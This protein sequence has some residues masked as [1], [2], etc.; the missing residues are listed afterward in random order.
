MSTFS[1]ISY[2]AFDPKNLIMTSFSPK[3]IEQK[4]NAPITYQESNFKYNYG[5][6][7]D[8]FYEE[9]P[10]LLNS[11]GIQEQTNTPQAGQN[12]Q[13]ANSG[14][15]RKTYQ[16]MSKLRPNVPDEA[17]LKTHL[18]LLRMAAAGLCIPYKVKIG[19]AEFAD[20]DIVK[21]LKPIYFLSKDKVT[22]AVLE[23]SSP[24]IYWPLFK[25]GYGVMEEKTTFV[26]LDGKVIPWEMLKGVEFEYKPLWKTSGVYVG[27]TRKIKTEL[28]SAVVRNIKMRQYV[29]AQKD[30]IASM[31][32][33]NPEMLKVFEDQ[34][35]KLKAE[36]EEIKATTANNPN[37]PAIAD[38]LGLTPNT[39]AVAGAKVP[40][41][42]PGATATTSVPQQNFQQQFQPPAQQ[43]SFQ[44]PPAQQQSFQQPPAQQQSFQQPPVQQQSPQQQF[45]LPQMPQMGNDMQLQLQQMMQQQ[46][47]QQQAQQQPPGMPNLA[48]FMKSGLP[49]IG[50]IQGLTP[51]VPQ[52]QTMPNVGGMKIN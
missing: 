25:R 35:R 51:G 19:L 29:D 21:C 16:I 1:K 28:Y 36:Q 49:Q 14:F 11:G 31:V 40:V 13:Q 46:Q 50:S 12:G 20:G 2:D 10:W 7:V 17:K 4:G 45:Q 8:D 41:A 3:S 5:T 52:F 18:D 22:G 6:V 24:S 23:G 47:Q 34:I 32:Q 38:G 43:Q 26:G 33:S 9:G 44:Q 42:A 37:N 48:D 39:F 15:S 30:T 27:S